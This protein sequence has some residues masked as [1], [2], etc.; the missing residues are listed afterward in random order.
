MVEATLATVSG[1]DSIGGA[2]QGAPP[3]LQ[4]KA[5]KGCWLFVAVLKECSVTILA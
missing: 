2:P 4:D 3:I 1:H 5:D